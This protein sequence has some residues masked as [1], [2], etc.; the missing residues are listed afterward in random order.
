MRIKIKLEKP[1]LAK[2]FERQE[3]SQELRN[4]NNHSYYIAAYS[5]QYNSNIFSCDL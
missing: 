5:L 3:H 4:S 1:N 2:S